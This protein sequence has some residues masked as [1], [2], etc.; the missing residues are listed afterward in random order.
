MSPTLTAA[1]EFELPDELAAHE[2]PEARGLTRDDV[3][4]MVSRIGDDAILHTRFH[5]LPDY[6]NAGDVLVVNSSATINAAFDAVRE[7][8]AG[9]TERLQLHLS[10][11]LSA[12]WWVI[13]LRRIAAHGHGP[14]LTAEAGE[15]LRL[16]GGA[17][18]VLIVPFNKD[19]SRY[20]GGARL[21]LA[22][23]SLPADTLAYA[24]RYGSP[25][26]YRYVRKQWPLSYYQS[27]FANEPGSVEMP[28]AGR[29]F[30]IDVVRRLEAKGVQIAP[31]VLH[32]GV[33]SLEV[34]EPPYPERYRVPRAT[35]AAINRGRAKGGRVIA[36]GTTAV[37]AVESA[38]SIDGVVQPGEGWTNLVITP[39][40]GLYAVAGLL[41]GL[42]APNASHLWLLE[43]L[44]GREHLIRCYEAALGRNYLWHEFGDLHLM[45]P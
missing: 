35:A 26:R 39:E 31:I 22:Q 4:L 34:E 1:L 29:P 14:L 9:R 45:L 21:W 16:P 41:T 40:R 24:A 23:V 18:A 13:E 42:H 11:P 8:R 25:I 6:L 19:D 27:V 33:S 36:V 15:I 12:D 5:D 10:T 37:R 2:P 3:K 38:A 43:A 17:R 44:A 7:T 28:S 30:T 32:T 20:D